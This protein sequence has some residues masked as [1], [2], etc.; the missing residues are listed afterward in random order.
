MNRRREESPVR[1]ERDEDGD[2]GVYE[3]TGRDASP[4]EAM[5]GSAGN[6]ASPSGADLVGGV[7]DIEDSARGEDIA[8][9]QIKR[10][11]AAGEEDAEITAQPAERP[12]RVETDWLDTTIELSAPPE[13]E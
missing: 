11:A 10:F 5:M 1:E 8:P 9:D 7:K 13:E 2:V 12:E 6:G 4:D 3:V